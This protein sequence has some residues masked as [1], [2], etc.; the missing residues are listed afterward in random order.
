[1]PLVNS[2]AE[3]NRTVDETFGSDT[4]APSAGSWR[5][6]L[7]SN[8]AAWLEWGKR[9][10]KLGIDF[11]TIAFKFRNMSP[12][13]PADA[14]IVS[15]FL[16]GTSVF[17]SGV[18]TFFSA[19]RVH[20]KDGWWD[21]VTSPQQ[22]RNTSDWLNADA[23]CKVYDTGIVLI[24][25]TTVPGITIR[26]E[27]R[28]NAAGRYLKIGQGVT[29][30]AAGN[31]GFVDMNLSR[32]AAIPA[33]N[34]WCEIY[35][36]G[37]VDGRLPTGPLLAISNVAAAGTVGTAV[38]GLPVFRFTFS[39]GNQIPL[40]LNQK[41]VCVLNGDYPVGPANVRWH[42]TDANIYPPG[43]MSIFGTGT[44]LDDQNYPM[45]QD[46]QSIPG[47]ADFGLWVTPRMFNG[48]EYDTPEIAGPLQQHLRSGTYAEGD[49]ICCTVN[50]LLQFLPETDVSR[51]WAQYANGTYPATRLLVT[52]RK[53]NRQVI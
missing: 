21:P 38:S 18:D 34:V 48:V 39:G 17:N 28:S 20:H 19:I 49:P 1:M 40:T 47:Y 36:Q 3:I 25:D 32:T 6:D 22:W 8:A 53:R 14:K 4:L 11:P 13:I 5:N 15:A 12:T 29:I 37:G 27:L 9:V 2:I 43:D 7:W 26:W 10:G 16:R 30:T 44:S 45:R 52:W 23:G 51:R 42:W 31:L 24:A 35:A 41:I 46:F 50:R 33:G